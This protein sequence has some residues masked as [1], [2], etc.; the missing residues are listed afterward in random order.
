MFFPLAFRLRN[1]GFYM[2]LLLTLRLQAQ[3]Q[4]LQTYHR[5]L[6]VVVTGDEI[7]GRK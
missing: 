5:P 2:F 3:V 7:C 6:L 4:S 1:E